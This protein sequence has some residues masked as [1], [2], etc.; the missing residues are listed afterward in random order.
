MLRSARSCVLCRQ[1]V[2]ASSQM[3]RPSGMAV[4]EDGG[5]TAAR[6]QRACMGQ[7]GVH[8]GMRDM[9][10]MCR[11]HIALFGVRQ[12]TQLRSCRAPAAVLSGFLHFRSSLEISCLPWSAPA[13]ETSCLVMLRSNSGS[14]R[15]SGHHAA[16]HLAARAHRLWGP[17]GPQRCL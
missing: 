15:R 5:D 7:P 10:S 6:K 4:Y 3:R 14:A 16:E 12:V 9:L 2:A 17:S 11:C 8:N 1:A 13:L